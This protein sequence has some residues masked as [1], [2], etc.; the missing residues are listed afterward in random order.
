MNINE[1]ESN[2]C[3]NDG[4]CQ[5]GDGGYKCICQP[6]F[7]GD[8]CQTDISVCNGTSDH[9]PPSTI[10]TCQNGGRCIDGQGFDYFC[11]CTAGMLLI[12]NVTWSVCRTYRLPDVRSRNHCTSPVGSVF[13]QGTH[14]E[15]KIQ[16][17]DILHFLTESLSGHSY[18]S[19]PKC[20][21]F[22]PKL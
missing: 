4:I 9:L 2:P 7:D 10:A 13:V 19:V 21:P 22:V 5:D 3:Q 12:P 17:P 20:R 16:L 14:M 15:I 18:I 11:E 6:G 8:F 1:C